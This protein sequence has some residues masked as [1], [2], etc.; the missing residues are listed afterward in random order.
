MVFFAGIIVSGLIKND[1]SLPEHL[2]LVPYVATFVGVA[3]AFGMF[4]VTAVRLFVGARR[5]KDGLYDRLAQQDADARGLTPEEYGVYKG[6]VGADTMPT[7]SAT[8][9]L[10]ISVVLTLLG[11]LVLVL[12]GVGIAQDMGLVDKPDDATTLSPVQWFF[13]LFSMIFIPWSWSYYLRERR[14]QKVRIARGLP[15]NLR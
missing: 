12:A 3:V 1:N 10:I 4:V 9:L 5:R 14:A 2:W 15:R 6:R 13:T 7:T 11:V 8:G